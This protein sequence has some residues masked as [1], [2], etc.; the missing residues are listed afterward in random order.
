MPQEREKYFIDH[1]YINR[2]LLIALHESL[3][4]QNHYAEILNAYDGGERMI[5][6]DIH[7]WIKRLR[8]CD[9]EMRSLAG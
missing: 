3:K 1:N 2:E 4:L 9:N 8:F 5:F 7:A 6:K